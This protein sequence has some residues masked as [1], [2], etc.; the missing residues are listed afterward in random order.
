MIEVI[1]PKD[2]TPDNFDKI[3]LVTEFCDSDLQKVFKS[4]NIFFELDDV[5]YITYQ[6]LCGYFFFYKC[7]N[8]L[9][10][11]HSANI[12]HRDLK[13]ANVLINGHGLTVKICD[14]GLARV[15]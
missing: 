11:L 10:Y 12:I 6:M 8:R 2:Q 4:D 3:Y 9:R 5:K 7:I 13:P 15:I 1:L 14:F